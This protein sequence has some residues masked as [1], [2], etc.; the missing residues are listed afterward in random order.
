MEL[1]FKD[2]NGEWVTY[3]EA[4]EQIMWLEE[5]IEL[6]KKIVKEGHKLLNNGYELQNIEVNTGNDLRQLLNNIEATLN[7]DEPQ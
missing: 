2:R 6:S 3:P 7:G 4:E 5:R 1:T